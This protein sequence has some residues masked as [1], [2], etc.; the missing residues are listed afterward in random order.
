MKLP[1][2]A[3]GFA[4][5]PGQPMHHHGLPRG[6]GL[7][8]HHIREH[9]G[10]KRNKTTLLS[11]GIAVVLVVTFLGFL[12]PPHAPPTPLMYFGLANNGQLDADLSN[13]ADPMSLHIHT[14]IWAI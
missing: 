6:Y 11:M 12:T 13:G 4:P 3:T 1:S 5:S 14:P 7:T 2:Q 9:P 8:P 10:F